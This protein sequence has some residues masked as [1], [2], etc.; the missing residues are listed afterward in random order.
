MMLAWSFAVRMIDEVARL[1]RCLGKHRYVKEVDH[2]VHWALDAALEDLPACAPH[3]AAFRALLASEPELQKG[4]RD[5]RL[6]RPASAEDVVAILTAMW[7]PGEA[8]AARRERLVHLFQEEGLPMGDHRPFASDPEVP[9]FPEL[10]ELNWVLLA[11]DELDAE[12]HAGVLAALEGSQEQFHPSQPIYQEGP[13]FSIVEI[14]DGAPLGILEDD[15]LIW[16][17]GPYEYV[18]YVFKGVS[19]AAKLAEAPVGVRALDGETPG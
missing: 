13:A 14:V 1:V 6:W 9:P 10:L 16:S 2:R 18:D 12:R 17:D 15:L 11:I 3:A 7:G 5:P 19:K 4:S 8:T